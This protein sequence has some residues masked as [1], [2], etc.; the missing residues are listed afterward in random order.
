MKIIKNSGDIVDFDQ[1]K[2][3][4]SLFR[5][6]ANEQNVEQI[7]GRISSQLHPGMKTK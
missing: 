4:K 2:L 6:G 7:V 1:E 3:K 5:S